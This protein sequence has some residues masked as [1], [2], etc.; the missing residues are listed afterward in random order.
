MTPGTPAADLRVQRRGLRS[1][2]TIPPEM[3]AE[4]AW[5]L[6]WLGLIYSAGGVFGFLARR[7][8]LV[9]GGDLDPVVHV[10]DAVAGVSIVMGFGVY[11]LY[12]NGGFTAKQLL[13]FGLVFEVAAAVGISA[14]QFWSGVPGLPPTSLTLIS[15]ECLWIVLYPLVVPT[16]PGKMLTASLLAA[17]AGPFTMG[18]ALWWAGVPQPSVLAIVSY[19]MPNYWAVAIAFAVSRIVQR[20]AVRLRHAREIGSYQLIE[21]IGEGGM[22]EVWRA[23]HRLLAR[24]AAIK[25][26]RADILGSSA[27][28]RDSIVRR[29]EREAQDTATLGSPHTINVY[30][31][32]VTEDGD[33]YYV[34]ELLHGLSLERYVE[35]F[36][37][38][39]PSRVSY[40]LG[41]VAHSLN[42]AHARGLVHRDV[43]PANIFM[44][45]LGLDYD[46]IK[47][48]DFGLVKHI[49]PS[50]PMITLDGTAAGTP[51]YMAPEVALGSSAVDSR[52][53]I[54]ALG[55]V[56]YFLLT[57][58]PVFAGETPMAAALSHIQDRAVAPS[59]RSEFSIPAELD[60]LILET[61]DKDPA[62]RPSTA[63]EFAS[64]L[65]DALK[66]AEPW[67]APAARS[68][69]ELH[70]ATIDGP[71]SASAQPDETAKPRVCRPR[72]D[73]E[74]ATRQPE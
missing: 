3:M 69:W 25:L 21:R 55:C 10:G 11:L 16:T 24:P 35:T 72:L 68:W 47:V 58:A 60:T 27:R 56:A 15:A 40:L 66:R 50:G 44:T 37:P 6:G 4:A 7:V 62:R 38:M 42:E 23:T 43:K 51:A 18:T 2:F 71:S 57:G 74:F 73:G 45:K 48:L 20:F 1:S 53:D 29:F 33:F 61:L 19:F 64:R 65:A 12:R 59:L 32:G 52:A 36:G 22:G 41:Q 67:T 13:D 17:S 14:S 34:M 70:Q 63:A 46:F 31:F 49:V 26:I 5:R 39:E 30:D 54:Y 8:L 28:V 9:I